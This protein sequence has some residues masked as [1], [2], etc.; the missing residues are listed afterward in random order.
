MILFQHSPQ[1]E[2]S[3]TNFCQKITNKVMMTLRLLTAEGLVK[4]IRHDRPVMRYISTNHRPNL[5]SLA[6]LK[7]FH[8][9]YGMCVFVYIDC[10]HTLIFYL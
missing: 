2:L 3:C 7:S 1:Y 5:H 6:K 10:I 8:L 9:A 4:A